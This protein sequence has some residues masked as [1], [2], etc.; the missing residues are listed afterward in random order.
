MAGCTSACLSN[1]RGLNVRLLLTIVRLP[2]NKINL[3][4]P[5]L[6]LCRIHARF[7]YFFL[8]RILS[9][10]CESVFSI[11]PHFCP[12][13]IKNKQIIFTSKINN[14]QIFFTSKIMLGHFSRRDNLLLV[15]FSQFWKNSYIVCCDQ[16]IKISIFKYVR[17]FSQKIK[18]L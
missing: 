5:N 2:Q 14:T 18:K 12:R 8:K 9:S 3:N 16:I 11:K 1:D 13:A 7:N 10:T 15:F 4:S 6:T 17:E